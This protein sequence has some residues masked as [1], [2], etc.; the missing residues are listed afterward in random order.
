MELNL[1]WNKSKSLP[2]RQILLMETQF[3]SAEDRKTHA[4]PNTRKTLTVLA[5]GPTINYFVMA[6]AK[7]CEGQTGSWSVLA[8]E[9]VC[10]CRE[11]KEGMFSHV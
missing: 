5:K 9:G 3:L 6:G 11:G 2:Y 4:L 10:G 1:V 7:V 8:G